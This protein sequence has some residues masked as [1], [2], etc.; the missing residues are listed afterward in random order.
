M[1]RGKEGGEGGS[2]FVLGSQ[3]AHVQRKR[4]KHKR[5]TQRGREV[6]EYPIE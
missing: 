4:E 3:E 2:K 6:E 5:S 1:I